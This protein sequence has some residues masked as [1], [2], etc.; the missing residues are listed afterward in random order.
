MRKDN[1]NILLLII[2]GS[3]LFGVSFYFM[4]NGILIDANAQI[5]K[6]MMSLESKNITNGNSQK[7]NWTGSVEI[8]KVIRD[9]F[10]PLIKVKLSE[11]ITNA[12]ADIGNNVSA[13]AAFIHPVKGYLVYVIYLLNDQNQVTKV[14]SD[15]G[16]GKILESKNMTVDEMMS[17]FHNDGGYTKTQNAYSNNH[18]MMGKV[19]DKN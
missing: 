5:E 6:E 2:L 13:V 3:S 18:F 15:I 14:L 4:N 1:S 7:S 9:S 16:T 10:D 8:S 19:M 11:A 12:E 17:A